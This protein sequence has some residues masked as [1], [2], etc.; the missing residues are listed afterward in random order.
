MGL[1]TGMLYVLVRIF[2]GIGYVNIIQF[3]YTNSNR[4]SGSWSAM[5]RISNGNVIGFGRK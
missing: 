5:I 4:S 1:V 3:C 2:E